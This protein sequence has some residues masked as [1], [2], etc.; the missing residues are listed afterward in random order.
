[1]KKSVKTEHIR[2]WMVALAVLFSFQF[3]TAVSAE[4]VATRLAEQ[5]LKKTPITAT[6]PGMTMEQAL[7]TQEKFVTCM[8]KEFGAP[9]GYKAGLT[10]P[11]AQK[12]FGIMQPVRGTM[13]EKMFL[14]NGVTLEKNPGIKIFA[15]GDLV[16][17][18]GSDAIN[19]AKTT[20]EALTSLDAVIPFVELPDVPFAAGFKMDGPALVAVNVAARYGVL[21]NPVA[22]TPSPEWMNKLKNFS[23]Q[24]YD[25]KGALFSEGKGSALLGDPLNVVLWIRDSLAAEG[26]KLKKGDLLSLGSITKMMP[27]KSGTTIKARFIDLDPKGPVEIVVSFNE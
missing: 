14:K 6:E 24:L 23:L 26:K 3:A 16:V 7:K 22:L 15:E 2:F 4:D 11:G 18:V 1:M 10:N 25:D 27:T 19:G 13:L 8:T 17:R 9:V 20:M 12:A 5:F 21:G